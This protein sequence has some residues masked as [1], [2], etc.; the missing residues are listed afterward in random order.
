MKRMVRMKRGVWGKELEE[1][2][3]KKLMK[4]PQ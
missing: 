1:K 2:I 4:I 3:I